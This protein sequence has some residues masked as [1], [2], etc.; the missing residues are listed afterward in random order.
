[1]FSAVPNGVKPAENIPLKS[2][3]CGVNLGT[4]WSNNARVYRMIARKFKMKIEPPGAPIMPKNTFSRR[5][6]WCKTTIK[7]AENI[8][9]KFRYCG[10]NLGTKWSNNARVYRMIARKI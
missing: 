5:P 7:P 10:V 3:Y 1:M 4:K 9:R 2:R 6:K 8:P